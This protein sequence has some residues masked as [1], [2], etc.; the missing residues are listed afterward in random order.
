VRQNG[1]S[2]AAVAAEP[3]NVERPLSLA[4]RIRA[5]QTRQSRS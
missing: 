5:L 4:E 3:A 2:R 1:P